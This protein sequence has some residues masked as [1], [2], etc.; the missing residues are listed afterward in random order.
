MFIPR[1]IMKFINFLKSKISAGGTT[2]KLIKRIDELERMS[3]EDKSK[4]IELIND[5]KLDEQLLR[6]NMYDDIDDHQNQ[7]NEIKRTTDKRLNYMDD[8]IANI[9]TKSTEEIAA[10]NSKVGKLDNTQDVLR[11]SIVYNDS[12]THKIKN[13]INVMNGNVYVDLD[14]NKIKN[15]Y[16]NI[17]HIFELLEKYNIHKPSTIS[18][19]IQK[20]ISAD[21]MDG[22]VESRL[23]RSGIY[24]LDI[25]TYNKDDLMKLSDFKKNL[26]DILEIRYKIT[27][28]GKRVSDNISSQVNGLNKSIMDKNK[29]IGTSQ[30]AKL[31]QAKTVSDYISYYTRIVMD[32]EKAYEKELLIVEDYFKAIKSVHIDVAWRR[33]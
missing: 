15:M 26:N 20:T 17:L 2:K 10:L 13:I 21:K 16:N 23:G 5:M 30:Q 6:N 4:I 32:L 7:I 8:D 19:D 3:R 22:V 29:K 24:N 27:T 9:R 33:T 25:F 14:F 1:M 28:I 11:S 18:S 12:E 31:D